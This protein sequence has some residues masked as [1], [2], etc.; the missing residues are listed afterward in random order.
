MVETS[1]T[2]SLPPTLSD[3]LAEMARAEGRPPESLVVDAVA[4]HVASALELRACILR[5]EA[6]LAA[7]RVVPHEE[8]MADLDAIIAAAEERTARR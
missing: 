2:V 1:L 8:V 4:Q 5:G 6:D 7:G 3:A